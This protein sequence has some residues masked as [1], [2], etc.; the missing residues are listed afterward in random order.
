LERSSSLV[1]PARGTVNPNSEARAETL[2]GI[3]NPLPAALR[4]K[5]DRGAFALNLN[6]R[7]PAT[8]DDLLKADSLHLSD[9]RAGESI[10][11]NRER[12]RVAVRKGSPE[13]EGEIV[14]TTSEQIEDG[15]DWS[16]VEREM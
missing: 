4:L 14:L 3:F 15:L 6:V 11:E 13:A 7:K 5:H 12:Q 2:D 10:R 8:D 16:S 1:A 9:V